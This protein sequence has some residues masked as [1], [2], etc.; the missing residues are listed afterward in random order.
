[1]TVSVTHEEQTTIFTL[2]G[3]V[4]IDYIDQLRQEAQDRLDG[5]GRDFVLDLSEV[6]FI[7]SAGLE[8]LIWLQ[9]QAEEQLGQV[10][11]AGVPENVE[12]ILELTRLSSRFEHDRDVAAAVEGL[13]I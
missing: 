10:R 4:T 9:E 5:D 1:M 8:T 12:K 11:L 3:E 2:R 13:G 7:D 6:E